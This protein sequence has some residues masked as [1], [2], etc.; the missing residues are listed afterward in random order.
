M[1]VHPVNGLDLC[2]WPSVESYCSHAKP[3]FCHSCITATSQLSLFKA[4]GART[5]KVLSMRFSRSS[6]YIR[7]AFFRYGP[8][9][10]AYFCTH[11]ISNDRGQ[12]TKRRTL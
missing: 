1:L 12:E 2:P 8:S 3:V 9:S 6:L 11:D 4:K 10:F 5:Q 7:F